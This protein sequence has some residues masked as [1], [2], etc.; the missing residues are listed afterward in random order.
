MDIMKYKDY[1]WPSNPK[2]LE[3]SH[4]RNV[5]E[6][7]LISGASVVQD[8]G[9]FCRVVQGEGE[10][11]GPSCL[12]Q[13]ERLVQIFQ[14]GEPGVLV[15][16]GHP[17]F[18]AHFRSLEALE[19]A[20]PELILYSFTFWEDGASVPDPGDSSSALEHTA[21]P[22]E[23]LW[24]IASLYHISID[25]LMARNRDISRPDRLPPGKRVKL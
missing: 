13:W 14:E 3:V 11:C 18:F 21:A 19:E 24:S 8:L 25:S 5:R 20:F 7:G 17:P 10:L 22:G 4:R 12:Q 2:R 6:M 23:T 15:L 1:T 9:T 16:P